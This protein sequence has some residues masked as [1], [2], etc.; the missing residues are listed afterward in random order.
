MCILA[1]KIVKEGYLFLVNLGLIGDKY[2]VRRNCA[3]LTIRKKRAHVFPPTF[4]A[5]QE[6]F[7]CPTLYL[8]S[9]ADKLTLVEKFH[10][11]AL[12]KIKLQNKG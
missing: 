5:E 9:F 10:T 12:V 3:I 1:E 4:G 8:L 6:M 7:Y 11:P 2:H